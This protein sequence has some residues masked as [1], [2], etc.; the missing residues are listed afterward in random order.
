[1]LMGEDA[2]GLPTIGQQ[3][4]TCEYLLHTQTIVGLDGLAGMN[5]QRRERT[6]IGDEKLTEML[7]LRLRDDQRRSKDAMRP[8]HEQGQQCIF[9]SIQ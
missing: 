1:M 7:S 9:K 4:K 3:Y 2:H 6:T 8:C 5:R